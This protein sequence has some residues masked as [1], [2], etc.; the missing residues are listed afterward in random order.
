MKSF[1][2][3]SVANFC[4]ASA[5]LL[6]TSSVFAIAP[7]YQFVP[8]A[9]GNP[10]GG[11]VTNTLNDVV[12][13]CFPNG[14]ENGTG[15]II[16]ATQPNAAGWSVISILTA[17]HVATSGVTLASF[18]QGPNATNPAGAYALTIPLSGAMKG[19]TLADANNA[20]NLPEDIEIMQAEVNINAL[21][22]PGLAELNLVLN[23][24][25]QFLLAPSAAAIPASTAPNPTMPNV[26]IR[27]FAPTAN[28]NFTQLGY[29]VGGIYDNTVPSYKDTQPADARRFQN[30]TITSATGASVNNFTNYFEPLVNFNV[31]AP[32][33]NGG[34][35][36]LPGDSGGPLL[37]GGA[38]DPGSKY[39]ITVTPSYLNAAP[40]G[41]PASGTAIPVTLNYTDYESAVFVGAQ[42]ASGAYSPPDLLITHNP[43]AALPAGTESGVPLIATGDRTTG[44]YDWAY[45]YANNPTLVPE[46]GTISLIA[47]GGLALL[48]RRAR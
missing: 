41:G 19:F 25:S 18:G 46:P 15:S 34:G 20:G 2:F 43:P 22:G 11:A 42:F 5:V 32:S 26:D 30:N 4:A 8:D 38:A 23:P 1:Q 16:G 6:A 35:G 33:K 13:L 27:N 37:T 45:Y 31:L 39:S 47:L 44:S 14:M 21:A 28:I 9:A 7:Q 40:P 29:G 17:N 3:K 24:L 12:A 10:G 48:R 36:G